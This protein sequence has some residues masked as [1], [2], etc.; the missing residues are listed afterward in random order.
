MEMTGKQV[1]LTSL[2]RP[3]AALSDLE[4]LKQCVPGLSG[5]LPPIH[6]DPWAFPALWT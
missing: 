3:S 2:T 5:P 4:V 1:I 6:E